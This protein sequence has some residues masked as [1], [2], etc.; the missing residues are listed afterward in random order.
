MSCRNA[1]FKA[2][3]KSNALV[4]ALLGLAASAHA[5]NDML[6]SHKQN[7]YK[8]YMGFSIE[9]IVGGPDIDI[10]F[11]QN[12]VNDAVFGGPWTWRYEGPINYKYA[13]GI[14][15]SFEAGVFYSPNVFAAVEFTY[16]NYEGNAN[17]GVSELTINGVGG[18]A[19]VVYTHSISDAYCLSGYFGASVGFGALNLVNTTYLLGHLASTTNTVSY[20]KTTKYPTGNID[21]GYKWEAMFKLRGGFSA[22]LEE[23][24]F[25]G[26][27]VVYLGASNLNNVSSIDSST[28]DATV[29]LS[30]NP[31]VPVAMNHGSFTM[32]NFNF[33]N[34][35]IELS[36]RIAFDS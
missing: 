27:G 3:N 13:S 15:S 7:N 11:S 25:L 2:L 9:A 33:S 26:I 28:E 19:S 16:M 20:I 23:S 35:G 12:G 21:N 5:G 6:Q 8:K 18:F 30:S 32:S 31:K 1:L 36:L 4:L 14:G 17:D 29:E 10:L 24:T 22:S 34:Y